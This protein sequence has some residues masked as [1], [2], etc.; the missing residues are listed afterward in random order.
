MRA[1]IGASVLISTIPVN[2][3]SWYT[4][5]FSKSL[6][7]NWRPCGGILSEYKG[8]ALGLSSKGCSKSLRDKSRPAAK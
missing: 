5:V 7:I 2:N 8:L 4:G 1:K 3:A 6:K